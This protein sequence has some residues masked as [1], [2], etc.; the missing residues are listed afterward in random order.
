MRAK[1]YGSLLDIQNKSISDKE[2][3]RRDK[4]LKKRSWCKE[5]LDRTELSGK[6]LSDTDINNRVSKIINEAK[7]VLKL[8]KKIG[9]NFL[10]EENDVINDLDMEHLWYGVGCEDFGGY[11]NDSNRIV[12]RVMGGE[13]EPIKNLDSRRRFQRWEEV[14]S[15]RGKKQVGQIL[16]D[17]E[18]VVASYGGFKGLVFG[19]FGWYSEQHSRFI[20][21]SSQAKRSSKKWNIEQCENF[22]SEVRSL[23]NKI[24]NVKDFGSFDIDRQAEL[25]QLKIKAVGI[26]TWSVG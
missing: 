4:A 3:R 19:V 6:S 7:Q 1:K 12:G 23:E 17:N 18:I 11:A 25:S 16:L 9:V 22:N 2:R 26:F 5:N 13:S 10:G 15:K 24:G 8:G 20:L 21:E 14:W